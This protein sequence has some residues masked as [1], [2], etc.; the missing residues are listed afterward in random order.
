MTRADIRPPEAVGVTAS[1]QVVRDYL[2]AVCRRGREP[3]PPVGVQ[4]NWA[5]QPSRHK[6]YLDV[7][8][9]PLPAGLGEGLGATSDALLGGPGRPDGPPWTLADLA[10]LLRLSAGVL[11][12]RL[13]VS[14][15]QD[16]H[17]RVL[18]PEALWCRGTAS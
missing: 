3:M 15:N 8:R 12:W 10:T 6:P 11:Q 13:S 16:S 14:W 5:D 18:Y 1:T 17:V 9:L 4:P 2:E 7:T